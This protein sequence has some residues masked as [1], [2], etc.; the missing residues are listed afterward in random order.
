MATSLRDTALPAQNNQNW[1][2]HYS[3]VDEATRR[4]EQSSLWL[5]SFQNAGGTRTDRQMM[6]DA[7]TYAAAQTQPQTI[8]LAPRD[9]DFSASSTTGW[10][11][12]PGFGLAGP[13][14][15]GLQAQEQDTKAPK[16]RVLANV[17]SGTQSLFYANGGGAG[18]SIYSP[19]T[20]TNIAWRS[21]NNLSQW[22]HAPFSA[23]NLYGATMG[24]L[25]F[26]GFKH[27]I[28]MP[29]DA[30]TIT[31]F[32]MW[33]AWNIPNMADEPFS[34]RGSD[35]WLVPDECNVGWNAAPTGK[36]LMRLENVQKTV[37]RGFYW[38]CRVG[39]SRALLVDNQ[40]STTQGSVF[41]SDCVI[42]GQNLSEPAGGALIYVNSNGVVNISD[43]ALN[44]GMGNPTQFTPDD[45]AYIMAVL[46]THGVLNVH[47]VN[48]T[49]ATGVSQDVP[50]V[51]QSGGGRV[52]VNRIIGMPG[53]GGGQLWTDLPAVT[54][55]A[56]YMETDATVRVV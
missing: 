55:S 39:G 50:I 51:S 17:G 1:Y 47:D 29:G 35:N 42:E 12:Y 9:H 10:N 23:V 7:M 37:L 3:A 27:C 34:L 43:I 40:A 48:V 33:G 15:A 54:S 53:N 20:V 31:L 4:A 32:T 28:G 22:L 52:Y 14:D 41:V 26:T 24:N 30:A 5:D 46:G 45:T 25:Q 44:F 11:V 16:C 19:M 8:R 49:R 6:G 21:T 13:S 56:G 18:A 36:Y 38:T 2:A